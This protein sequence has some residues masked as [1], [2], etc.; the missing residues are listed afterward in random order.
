MIQSGTTMIAPRPAYC[1]AQ[2]KAS[3][4]IVQ[5]SLDRLAEIAPEID[6]IDAEEKQSQADDERQYREP[7]QRGHDRPAEDFVHEWFSLHAVSARHILA[8]PN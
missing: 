6:R 8:T 4:T 1:E 3:M 7:Q 5:A 2:S